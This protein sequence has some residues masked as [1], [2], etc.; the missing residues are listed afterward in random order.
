MS[1]D[2][3]ESK[4]ARASAYTSLR[5]DLLARAIVVACADEPES[6]DDRRDERGKV[7]V[8]RVVAVGQCL[9]CRTTSDENRRN[10]CA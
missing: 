6:R 5:S 3:S 10:P 8:R 9:E 2:K 7:D 1:Q 4:N